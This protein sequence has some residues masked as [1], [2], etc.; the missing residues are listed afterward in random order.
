MNV[1]R[2][3]GFTLLELLVAMTIFAIVTLLAYRGIA[4]TAEVKVALDQRAA[5]SRE[6]A[7][8]FERLEQDLMFVA[9]QSWRSA[10]GVRHAALELTPAGGLR[11]LRSGAKGSVMR[12]D[13][14]LAARELNITLWPEPAAREA[15]PAYRLLNDVTRFEIRVLDAEGQWQSRWPLKEGDMAMPRALELVLARDGVADIRR[16]MVLP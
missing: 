12:V 4:Q 16:V 1:R 2:L 15:P 14:R 10:D 8:V 13:Y 9:A 3:A 6:T 11:L 7:L 5:Q